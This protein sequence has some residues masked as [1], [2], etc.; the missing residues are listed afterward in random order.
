M[1]D[2][3]LSWLS[4]PAVAARFATLAKGA[5]A[6]TPVSLTLPLGEGENDWLAALP[7]QGSAFYL[8]H[9]G[10]R[11]WTLGLGAALEFVTS[12]P[13]RF[14]ALRSAAEGVYAAGRWDEAPRMFFGFSFASRA[15]DGPAA[16]LVLPTLVL[17]CRDGR[18]SLSLNGLA[19]SF[20]A[21]LAAAKALLAQAD[22][23]GP[24]PAL[25]QP[26]DLHDEAWL[27]RV[28]SALREIASGRCEKLVLA[29]EAR[30]IAARPIPPAPLLA[31]LLA[32]QPDCLTY[33]AGDG[34]RIFLGAT[35]ETLVRLSGGHAEADALAGSAWSD[36]DSSLDSDKNRREQAHVV[37]A[38][39]AALAPLCTGHV[40]A[41][42]DEVVH[43]GHL[44]HRRTRVSG[45]PRPGIGLFDL[46]DALHPTPAV[47]GHPRPEA[48]EWLHRH[49]EERP[50]WYS[51]GIGEIGPAGQGAAAVALRCALLEGA[52]ARLWAGAGIVAGSDPRAE[53][54]ETEAKF[55]TL[56]TALAHPLPPLSSRPPHRISA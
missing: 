3:A 55:H 12:G 47:G 37:S 53:L 20:P 13:G 35:P 22:G 29:R 15:S 44:S 6:S 48:L 36:G 27:T 17:D 24:V 34:H 41:S 30:F 49:G 1:I 8:A 39:R 32:R 50:A 52:E 16:R 54:A 2:A 5:A 4:A 14:A 51:G 25:R 31:T 38:V 21:G 7:A 19:G 28:R 18:S 43:L 9:P 26:R 40:L 42:A 23:R 11:R 46:I 33:A 45:Q 56:A 10:Q